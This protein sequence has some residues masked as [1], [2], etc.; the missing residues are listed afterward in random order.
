MSFNYPLNDEGKAAWFDLIVDDFEDYIENYW[1]FAKGIDCEEDYP[2]PKSDKEKDILDDF[3]IED[4]FRCE[5]GGECYFDQSL[6]DTFLIKNKSYSLDY[7]ANVSSSQRL[8]GSTPSL[9]EIKMMSL[10]SQRYLSKHSYEIVVFNSF[11]REANIPL[12]DI[13]KGSLATTNA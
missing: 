6:A 11:A 8:V 4:S 10:W 13:I 1:S 3:I 9:I 2:M 7:A 5:L 12:D